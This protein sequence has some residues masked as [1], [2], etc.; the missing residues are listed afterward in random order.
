MVCY[1]YYKFYSFYLSYFF[2]NN[3]EKKFRL[4]LLSKLYIIEG[5]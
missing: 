3:L 5:K 4:K 1:Y 2:K